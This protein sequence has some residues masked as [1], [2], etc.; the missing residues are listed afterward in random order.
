MPKQ[1]FYT[2]WYGITLL[3]ISIIY[4]GVLHPEFDLILSSGESNH[5]RGKLGCVGYGN[6][7][8][9]LVSTDPS[10]ISIAPHSSVNGLA[11]NEFL[12]KISPCFILRGDLCNTNGMQ[13]RPRWLIKGS[14]KTQPNE[15]DRLTGLLSPLSVALVPSGPTAHLS[16]VQFQLY[17]QES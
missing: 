3:E 16:P 6:E 13:S 12:S 11:S 8:P 10:R 9:S 17:Q 7:H 4:D 1:G 14:I 15:F 2:Y 5:W